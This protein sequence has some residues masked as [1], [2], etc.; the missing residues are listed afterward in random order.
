MIVKYNLI[1]SSAWL[2]Y[3]SGSKNSR[4]FS[5]A[6]EDSDHLL[7]PTLVLHEVFKK[8]VAEI[9]ESKARLYITNMKRGRTIDLDTEIALM[10][11]KKSIQHRLPTAD[12]IIYASAQKHQ[13]TLWT[14]D[15][16]FKGLE[17]VQ[18]FKKN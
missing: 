7:V 15:A 6:I 2:E 11:A 12:S 3:F 1:D 4:H 18:Y 5:K 9:G 17:G 13:A 10:A 16:D 14:Q 8:L